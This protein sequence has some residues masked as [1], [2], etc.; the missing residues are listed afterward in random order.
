MSNNPWRLYRPEWV[1]AHTVTLG[2]TDPINVVELANKWVD[3]NLKGRVLDTEIQLEVG[4]DGPLTF[5]CH[6]K[7]FK[8]NLKG[9]FR[10]TESAETFAQ[11]RGFDEYIIVERNSVEDQKIRTYGVVS[12]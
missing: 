11:T 12:T 6:I 3:Q 7:V 9:E 5:W 1:I 10:Y 8:N 2:T 4:S